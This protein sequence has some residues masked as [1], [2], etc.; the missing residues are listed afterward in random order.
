LIKIKPIKCIEAIQ[1]T[2]NNSGAMRDLLETK[3]FIRKGELKIITIEYQPVKL[4]DYVVKDSDGEFFT[5][6]P[7]IFKN[8]NKKIKR[9][10]I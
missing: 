9:D 5:C 4:G 1:W 2:G 3:A 7:K 6:S 8:I 10:L